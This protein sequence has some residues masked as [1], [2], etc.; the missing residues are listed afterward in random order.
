MKFDTEI[1]LRKKYGLPPPSSLADWEHHLSLDETA[2][3]KALSAKYEN[4]ERIDQTDL[5]QV[6]S[7]MLA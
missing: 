3:I 5:M 4:A 6:E 7:W 1:E 2:A